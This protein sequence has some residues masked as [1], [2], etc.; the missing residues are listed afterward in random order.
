M[1]FKDSIG[2]DI[3]ENDVVFVLLKGSLKGVILKT[4]AVYSLE[5]GISEREKMSAIG[6]F[7]SDF[8]TENKAGGVEIYMGI[9]LRMMMF[10]EI[11]FPLAVKENLR[12]TLK[13]E[14]NKY[15]P[16]ATDDIYFDYQIIEEQK[17]KNR[18][19]IILAVVKKH[20]LKPFVDFCGVNNGR[21]SG[22]ETISTAYANAY[23]YVSGGKKKCSD[24][25]I[26]KIIAGN[27]DIDMPDTLFSEE[28]MSQI[29][30][31]SSDLLPAFGLALKGV[32]ELSPVQLNLLPVG[33]R[34]K[35]SRF[36]YYMMILLIGIIIC[37][38][39][40]WAGTRI[41]QKKMKLRELEKDMMH[42]TEEVA[43]INQTRERIHSLELSLNNLN[44]LNRGN[45]SVTDILRELTQVIPDTAWI[46][47]FSYS[48]KG[49]RL[50]GFADSASGLIPILE[51]SQLFEDVVFLSAIIKDK[52]TGK[53]R[54]NIGMKLTPDTPKTEAIND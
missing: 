27:Q 36:G 42:L 19:G 3:R 20:D 5:S 39:F 28:E 22:I 26:R 15:I 40:T 13:Y 9:P 33:L 49:I 7:L 14:I 45:N 46:R 30:V 51:E 32:W 25:E 38:G 34:K 52:K 48:D 41:F 47:E 16:L 50:Y 54:F 17:E 4:H 37:C 29:Q 44:I 11:E 1:N 35:P 53:E 43:F 8:T 2:I 23:A 10:R 12:S 18:L 6:M 31:P 21:I 24:P